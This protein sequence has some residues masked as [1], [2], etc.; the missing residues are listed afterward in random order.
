[1]W[2]RVTA[3]GISNFSSL[4]LLAWFTTWKQSY[5]RG[6]QHPVQMTSLSTA[7]VTSLSLHCSSK[8]MSALPN[9]PAISLRVAGTGQMT[10]TT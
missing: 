2:V 7:P 1:M 8:D 3:P 4:L 9:L 6:T 10:A 5:D